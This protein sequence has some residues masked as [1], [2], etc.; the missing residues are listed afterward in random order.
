MYYNDINEVRLSGYLTADPTFIRST[1]ENG[2]DFAKI[3]LAI[4]RS[5]THQK[6]R[7]S[8]TLFSEVLLNNKTDMKML[9]H[10]KKGDRVYVAGKL[11]INKPWKNN[12]GVIHVKP[13]IVANDQTLRVLS[14]KTDQDIIEASEVEFE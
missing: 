14:S 12:D 9:S 8:N 11:R 4:N 13:V 6:K 7:C 3:G 5:W 2:S 10:L 1:K